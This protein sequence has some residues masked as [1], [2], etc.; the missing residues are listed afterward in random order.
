[1]RHDS[2]F[3]GPRPR[4]PPDRHRP[5]SRTMVLI[6]SDR[7]RA[8]RTNG[9]KSKGPTSPEGLQKAAR[10]SVK[11]N[12]CSHGAALTD[13][14]A[15]EARR[16][17]QELEAEHRPSTATSRILVNRMAVHASAMARCARYLDALTAELVRNALAAYE[18]RRLSLVEK[19]F[20][21]LAGQPAT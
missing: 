2:A 16:L 21:W 3:R 19:D 13:A 20:D 4:H 14:D 6:T 10:N 11:H 18:D 12:L 5:R 8:S 17:L 9:Q 15:A 1:R 7:Q